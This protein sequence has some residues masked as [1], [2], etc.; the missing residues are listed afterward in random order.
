MVIVNFP[1]TTEQ[2]TTCRNIPKTPERKTSLLLGSRLSVS[3]VGRTLGTLA[4][5][6]VLAAGKTELAELGNSLVLLLIGDLALRDGGSVRGDGEGGVDGD[7]GSGGELLLGGITLLGLAEAAGEED[8]LRLVGLETLNVGSERRNGAVDAAVVDGDANG[9][10]VGSGDL[11][12][13]QLLQ[14]ETTTSTNA[15]VVLLGRASDNG[16]ELVDGAGS[17]SGSL[18]DPGVPPAE[19]AARLV[20][21][22]ADALLPV[23]PEVVVGD[24]LIVL[25]RHFV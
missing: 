23:L 7:L 22:R 25:N 10:G 24:L 13:L 9:A 8:E 14:G 5:V 12:S 11:S 17:D 2:N 1:E 6:A 18:G 15:A 20:E 4:S 16:A 3:L 19:L 21:V